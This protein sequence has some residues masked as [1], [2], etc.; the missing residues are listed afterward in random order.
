MKTEMSAYWLSRDGVS[1]PE[2]PFSLV[3]LQAM[4]AAGHVTALSRVCREGEQLWMPVESVVS[5]KAIAWAP[6]PLPFGPPPVKRGHPVNQKKH[7]SAVT[8]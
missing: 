1:D 8:F 3:Q 4:F 7:G 6:P 2:G 5:P